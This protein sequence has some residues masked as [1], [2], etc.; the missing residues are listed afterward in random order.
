[1][2]GA[3]TLCG[4][5]SPAPLGSPVDRRFLESMRDG[6]DASLMGSNTLRH[7]NPEMRG[8]DSGLSRRL[9]AFITMSGDI[10]IEGKK[11]FAQGPKPLVFCREDKQA[12]LCER[13]RNRAEVI[14]LPPFHGG[15]SI[16]AAVRELGKR[17]AGSILVEGG[18]I[19]NYW[20]LRER[21]VDEIL[22]TITPQLFGGEGAPSLT[23]G[24]DPLGC[25][26]LALELLSCRQEKS[27]ELFTHYRVKYEEHHA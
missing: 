21:V 11:I 25:P 2:I 10:P 26:F 4:R 5:I 18:A 13:L 22:V 9:R 14:A 16:A 7:G 15:L 17:G 6:T 19:L 20:A 23:E 27:G 8:S 12:D 3:M 24:S 1:M